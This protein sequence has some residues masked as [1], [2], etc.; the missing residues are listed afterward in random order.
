MLIS[1]N[2]VPWKLPPFPGETEAALRERRDR[3]M[4]AY[5]RS[6]TDQFWRRIGLEP[7]VRNA[8]VVD[9][10]CG[11]GVLSIDLANRGAA[12]VVGLD[13]DTDAISF[14]SNYVPDAFPLLKGKLRFVPHDIGGL[15]GSEV[16]DFVFSKDAFEHVLDLKSV[17][18]FTYRLLKPGG[19]LI[20][21]T[22]PL[23]LQPLWR[24]RPA[25]ISDPLADGLSGIASLQVCGLEEL[26]AL[27]ECRR[28]WVK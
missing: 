17:V 2:V 13:I 24:P 16:F 22:S 10:G 9:L 14:A 23:V 3:A 6:S 21:G 25:G 4:L 28:R 12:E 1:D 26:D 11:H 20:I 27:A 8:R 19:G 7:D 18:E 15:S 5:Q